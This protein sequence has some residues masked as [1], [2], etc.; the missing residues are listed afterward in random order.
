MVPNIHSPQ[1]SLRRRSELSLPAL[2][3]D[4]EGNLVLQEVLN[5]VTHGVGIVLCII[6]TYLLN[7]RASIY[8]TLV[9]DSAGP[10]QNACYMYSASLIT[11]Y[12]SS[13]LYHSFFALKTT[14]AVFSVFDHCA[15]YMLIAGT[16]TPMLCITFPD[17]PLYNFWILGFLW[18]CTAI[19]ML[20][21][22]FC[23][24]ATWKSKVS[25]A[26][27]KRGWWRAAANDALRVARPGRPRSAQHS[28]RFA[29]PLQHSLTLAHSH[30][31]A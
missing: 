28:T 25:G 15:I 14:K 4:M 16:Y 21:E 19:G 9:P 13:T 11:L 20:I 8:S 24:K 5:S 31:S 27:A 10:I 29:S 26:R 3:V 1:D 30:R 23:Q 6:G 22:A 18:I 2:L 17:K 7:E 12:A